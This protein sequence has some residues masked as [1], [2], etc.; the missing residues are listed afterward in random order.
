MTP[1][2]EPLGK[3]RWGSRESKPG[4]MRA[5]RTPT[6]AARFHPRDQPDVERGPDPAPGRPIG[7]VNLDA[8]PTGAVRARTRAPCLPQGV[9][10]SGGASGRPPRLDAPEEQQADDEEAADGEDA[11][12]LVTARG[13]R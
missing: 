8:A 5:L 2:A 11:Q 13:V 10:C 9:P 1:P 12:T 3:V 7:G 4:A 6:T